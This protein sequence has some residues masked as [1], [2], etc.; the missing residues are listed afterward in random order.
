M[1]KKSLTPYRQAIGSLQYI[2]TCTRWNL[3]FS[4]NHFAQFISNPAP[5][6]PLGE[7]ELK[8]YLDSYEEPQTKDSFTLELHLLA[9][10][11]CYLDGV[12]PTRLTILIVVRPLHVMYFK[13]I[14]SILYIGKI[15]SNQTSHSPQ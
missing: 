7:L 5:V 3:A 13:W 15:A 10:L 6:H 9:L 2:V 1:I 14:H 12:T 8:E 11:T 4:M